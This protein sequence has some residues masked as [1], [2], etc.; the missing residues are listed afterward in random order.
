LLSSQEEA[1]HAIMINEAAKSN[2]FF[3]LYLIKNQR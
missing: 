2:F 3:I 1:T